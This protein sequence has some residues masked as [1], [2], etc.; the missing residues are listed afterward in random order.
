MGFF[1]RLGS[2][3]SSGLHS[4]ARLGKKTLGN[5]SRVGNTIAHGAEKAINVVDRIPIV[6]QVLAPISGV[7]RSGVGL[8]K[9][10]ADAADAGRELLDKGDKMLSAGESVLKSKL[11]KGSNLAKEVNVKDMG[12][13]AFKEGRNEVRS[14]ISGM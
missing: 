12:K 7:V 4:A 6:G 5:V 13:Q 1:S 14:R 8:V 11:E 2:R 9:D 10:V 3:I